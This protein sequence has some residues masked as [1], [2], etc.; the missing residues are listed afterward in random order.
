MRF[1]EGVAVLAQAK[2][3]DAE[4]YPHVIRRHTVRVELHS[5]VLGTLLRE[6]QQP[7][8]CSVRDVAMLQGFVEV[9]VLHPVLVNRLQL[10]TVR[11]LPR[12]LLISAV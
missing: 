10:H 9:P 11:V 3:V 2:L 12:K 1:T 7:V 6:L 4:Q 8:D 5:R